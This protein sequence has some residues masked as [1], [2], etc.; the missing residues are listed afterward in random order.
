[1]KSWTNE[2]LIEAVKTSTYFSQILDKL[3]INKNGGNYCWIKKY[4]QKLQLDTS[5]LTKIITSNNLRSNKKELSELLTINPN[6]YNNKNLK[7]RLIKE[8]ILQYKC[9]ECNLTEWKN[10]HICLQLDHINGIHIDNRLENLRLLCPNCHSQTDTYAGKN[11]KNRRIK[12]LCMKCNHSMKKG[13]KD[14]KICANCYNSRGSQKI[15]KPRTTKI[16]WPSFDEVLQLVTSTN[17]TQAGK[18]LGVSDNAIRKFLKKRV[19][20][21]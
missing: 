3:N 8:N 11:T 17:F 5:H 15:H 20:K 2:Q 4:I 7:N 9:S 14:R 18:T 13:K 10:K 21:I 6:Y 12:K 1:M 19:A 16:H